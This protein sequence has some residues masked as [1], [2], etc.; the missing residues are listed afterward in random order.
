MVPQHLASHPDR[1][2]PRYAK[3]VKFNAF[4]I[5][6]DKGVC[7]MKKVSRHAR[8]R[9]GGSAL[10]LSHHKPMRDGD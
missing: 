10:S 4:P 7:D 5:W 9:S 3:V 8:L 2:N 6:D 1:L